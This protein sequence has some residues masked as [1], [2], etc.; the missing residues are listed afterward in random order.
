VSRLTTPPYALQIEVD[1]APIVVLPPAGVD[2]PAAIADVCDWLDW[3]L[4]AGAARRMTLL[5]ALGWVMGADNAPLDLR[6][7]AAAVLLPH[8]VG[9]PAENAAGT[10]PAARGVSHRH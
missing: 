7:E 9:D 8:V 10:G 6:L 5:D 3:C 4:G 2:R 1:G